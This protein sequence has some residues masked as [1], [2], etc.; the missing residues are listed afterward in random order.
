MY[1]QIKQ[2]LTQKDAHVSTDGPPN[3]GQAIKLLL[4]EKTRDGEEKSIR[5]LAK[6]TKINEKTLFN[7]VSGKIQNPSWDKLEAVSEALGVDVTELVLRAKEMF[8]GN[9]VICGFKERAVIQFS[10]HGFS[11]QT[12]TPPGARYRD[13]FMGLVTIEPQ[14]QVGP[15]KTTA[16]T[17]I[18]I[19][20][21]DGTLEV[22]Y[23]ENKRQ[24]LS[25]NESVYFDATVEHRFHNIDTV[26]AKLI[27]ATHPPLY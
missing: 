26:P 1:D 17:T 5:W 19:Y 21:T 10:Q 18:C 16:P 6:K 4:A 20:V 25:A 8:D 3:F 2:E 7:I 9:F 14:K 12:F 13:F 23:G 27:M 15:W 24:I 22:F 11:I